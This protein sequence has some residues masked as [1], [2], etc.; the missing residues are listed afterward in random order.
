MI[1]WLAR[2]DFVLCNFVI[3]SEP[4]KVYLLFRLIS[5]LYIIARKIHLLLISTSRGEAS[6]ETLLVHFL[7][8]TTKLI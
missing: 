3:V 1:L 4:D 6:I 2:I 7:L 5:I 8:H